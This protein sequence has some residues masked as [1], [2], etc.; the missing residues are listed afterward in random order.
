MAEQVSESG[1]SEQGT[2]SKPFVDLSA[3]DPGDFE[4]AEDRELD[5]EGAAE[6]E[7]GDE[8]ETAADA[9]PGEQEEETFLSKEELAEIDKKSPEYRAAYAQLLKAYSRKLAQ[10]SKPP[11]A[12]KADDG[13]QA[14]ADAPAGEPG[15]QPAQGPGDYFDVDFSAWKPAMEPEPEESTLRGAETDF[16]RRVARLIEQGIK[17][18]LSTI[19]GRDAALRQQMQVQTAEQRISGYIEAIKD[20]P[21]FEEKMSLL[22]KVAPGTKDLAFNQPELWLQMAEGV[23]G[24]AANWRD[25]VDASEQQRGAQARRLAAKPRATVQRPTRAAAPRDDDA[26]SSSFDDAFERS[27]RRVAR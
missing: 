9:A 21:Q 10:R 6:P 23:T 19:A 25:A 13:A 4:T 17:H 11:E 5:G 2:E 8:P 15:A 14:A 18:T 24:I 26:D 27:W 22:A 3:P 1:R 20:H 12:A 16:D 7:A